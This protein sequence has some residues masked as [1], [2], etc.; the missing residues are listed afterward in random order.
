MELLA[1]CTGN[2]SCGI[3]EFACAT[4]EQCIPVDWLC[5]GDRDCLD[6]SDETDCGETFSLNTIEDILFHDLPP[7]PIQHSVWSEIITSQ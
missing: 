1:C 6:A 3:S 5:D 2:H 7:S 4:R